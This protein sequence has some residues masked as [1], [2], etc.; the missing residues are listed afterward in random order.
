MKQ[1]PKMGVNRTG[2]QMSPFDAGDMK[3]DVG[4]LMPEP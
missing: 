1:Q 2:I 3:D 4:I